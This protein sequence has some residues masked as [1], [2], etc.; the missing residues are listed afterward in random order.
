VKRP[1]PTV[2]A[3]VLVAAIACL[4]LAM[5]THADRGR[6]TSFPATKAPS[7]LYAPPQTP[8]QAPQQ[9]TQRAAPP[10]A[11]VRDESRSDY[12]PATKAPSRLYR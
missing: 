10:D 2:R 8:R 5:C 7:Q 3:A 12:F 11:P 1:P 4:G 6:D 9:A